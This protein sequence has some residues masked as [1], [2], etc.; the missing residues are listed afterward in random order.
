MEAPPSDDKR[1][2]NGKALIG[3]H[4]IL[5]RVPKGGG[6]IRLFFKQNKT[7]Y[8]KG[9]VANILPSILWIFGFSGGSIP[10]K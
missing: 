1:V 6:P 5:I 3:E 4:H 10:W 9:K 8:E 2:D 7:F